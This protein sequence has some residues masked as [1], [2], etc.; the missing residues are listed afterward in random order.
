VSVG[1]VKAPRAKVYNALV[2]A[3]FPT[4]ASPWSRPRIPAGG[5][6]VPRVITVKH[7]RV[8]KSAGAWPVCQGWRYVPI[9]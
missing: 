2:D 9:S 4:R 3:K 6:A 8:V 5:R 7:R 1:L